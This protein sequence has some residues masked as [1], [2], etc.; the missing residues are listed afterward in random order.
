MGFCLGA[1]LAGNSDD[2]PGFNLLPP[3]VNVVSEIQQKH[4]EVTNTKDT[5]IQLD[6]KYTSGKVE[7]NK[8]A[9]FQEGAATMGLNGFFNNG[10]RGRI[11]ANYSMNDNVA[12]SVT[13]Y[14]RGWVGVVGTH[15]EADKSWCKCPL[16][17]MSRNTTANMCLDK[18]E[19]ISNP[20]GYSY[21]M[22]FDFIN[23]TLNA[24][25]ATP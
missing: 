7:H 10:G 14:G 8:W 12:A 9:Y 21:D 5:I 19:K 4:A 11:I 25:K 24:G 22:G 2:F 1:Y 15:P 17:R 23:A 3:G 18:L 16:P 13:P 6:W 20:D